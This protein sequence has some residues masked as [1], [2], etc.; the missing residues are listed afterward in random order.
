MIW[1]AI[2]DAD[3]Y[4][5]SEF[6]PVAADNLRYLMDEYRVDRHD[7]V[8]FHMTEDAENGHHIVY[9]GVTYKGGFGYNLWVASKYLEL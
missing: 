8:K 9:E 7:A 3:T 5:I 6:K 2:E 1:L 4:E